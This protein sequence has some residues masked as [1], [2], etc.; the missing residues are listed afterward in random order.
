MNWKAIVLGGLAYYVAAFIVSMV[1]GALIHE[2]VLDSPSSSSSCSR[3]SQ[4]FQ[5]SQY[6]QKATLI[7]M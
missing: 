1:G 3:A 7:A 2:G 5:R 4:A 6:Q